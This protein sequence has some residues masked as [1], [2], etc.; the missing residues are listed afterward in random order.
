MAEIAMLSEVDASRFSIHNG[1]KSK[2]VGFPAHIQAGHVLAK[3]ACAIPEQ[4]ICLWNSSF[5]MWYARGTAPYGVCVPLAS[6][7]GTGKFGSTLP[8]TTRR[9]SGLLTFECNCETS[10][11]VL[12][13]GGSSSSWFLVGTDTCGLDLA[14]CRKNPF[15]TPRISLAPLLF[16][17]CVSL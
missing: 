13:L 8:E 10:G 1:N 6:L 16:S 3:T 14:N 17:S 9:W 11:R 7:P 4:P 12:V 2:N 5:V 15:M